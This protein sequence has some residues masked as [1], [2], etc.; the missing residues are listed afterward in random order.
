M[1]SSTT[2]AD[3]THG[4]DEGDGKVHAHVSSPLFLISIFAALIFLTIVTV[5]VSY[6]DLGTANTFVAMLIATMKATL[7]AAFFMHLRYDKPLHTIVFVASFVFLAIF[8]LFSLD[9]LRTR[10][11]I[12][13][14]NGGVINP[15]N[16]QVA[17]GGIQ[18]PAAPAGSAPAAEHGEAPAAGGEHH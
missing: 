5:A 11:R 7:V 8:L 14:V 9:D 15:A 2:P 12:D 13:A 10:G 18:I 3:S 16:G 17:P 4:H 1:S 6:V